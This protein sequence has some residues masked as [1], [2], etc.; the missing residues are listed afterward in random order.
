MIH[1]PL[2]KKEARLS[3][4]FFAKTKTKTD[5]RKKDRMMAQRIDPHLI[6]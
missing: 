2:S 3:I 6:F 4:I 5:T 1:I